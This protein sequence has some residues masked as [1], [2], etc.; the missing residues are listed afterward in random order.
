MHEDYRKKTEQEAEKIRKEMEKQHERDIQ[1]RKE[2]MEKAIERQKEEI[3][4]ETK[5]AR[6]ELERQRE[7]AVDALD[8]TKNQTD[9][10]VNIDTGSS[11]SPQYTDTFLKVQLNPL[12]LQLPDILCPKVRA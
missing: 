12:L 8:R 7:M 3:A 6:K 2:L 10:Q 5:Y 4:L 9:V 11:T 1:F